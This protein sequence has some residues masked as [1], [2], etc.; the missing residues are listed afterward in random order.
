M[1]SDNVLERVTEL[2]GLIDGWLRFQQ[3]Y[4]ELPSIG[5][6]IGVGDDVVYAAG[7]GDADVERH[8]AATERTRYRIA[9]HSKVFTAT[10]ILALVHEGTLRLDDPV[11]THVDWF[12]SRSNPELE[13]VTIRQLLSH[14]AGITRDG[15]TTHWFDDRFPDIEAIAAQVDDGMGVLAPVEKL[16]YS[17]IGYTLLGQVIEAVTG[18]GYE[19]HVDATILAPLGLGATT[20]DLPDDLTDHA[21][22]YPMRLPGRERPPFAHV[23][24]GVMNSATGFSSSVV[25]LLRWYRAHLLESGELFPDRIKREM[26]RVQFESPTMRWGLGFQLAKHGEMDFVTHGG[27]YPGFITYSGVNQ[28]HRLAIVVLTNSIDGPAREIFGGI[29]NLVKKA[30]AGD[31]ESGDSALDRSMADRVAGIYEGRWNIEQVGRVGARMVSMFPTQ[32]DPASTLQLLEH[33]E[34]LRFSLPDTIPTGAPGEEVRF[35]P[36]DPPVRHA[37]ATPPTPRSEPWSSR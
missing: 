36:A 24:A 15:V 20:P 5:V 34:G 33:I 35:Q 37:P 30:I 31:F 18:M 16:K 14:S 11:S 27:G 21:L 22:G 1:A 28:K 23:R 32:V 7:F 2:S 12:R 9:S 8:I 13:Y 17:N 6:G 25:D 29:A 10:A 4:Q 26:Q 19:R 3:W